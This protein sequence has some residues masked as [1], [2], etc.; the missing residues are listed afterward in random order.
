MKFKT[1]I[2]SCLAIAIIGMFLLMNGC[3]GVQVKSNC[4]VQA[5]HHCPTL[6]LHGYETRIVSGPTAKPGVDHC[7]CQFMVDGM[8]EYATF[9]D[10]YTVGIGKQDWNYEPTK[11]WT[12]DEAVHWITG[13]K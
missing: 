1:V 11:V 7:Q 5:V 10:Q 2:G 4:T 12:T 6:E 13:G 9:I 3:A 8:W